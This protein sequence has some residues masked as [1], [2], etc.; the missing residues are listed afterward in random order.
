MSNQNKLTIHKSISTASNKDKA[1]SSLRSP[2]DQ[3]A[4]GTMSQESTARGKVSKNTVSN[5]DL[6]AVESKQFFY[7]P[8]ELKDRE[9][10]IQYSDDEEISNS[11][12]RPRKNEN[13]EEFIEY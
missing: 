6:E 4:P 5:I 12:R 3:L 2:N 8:V 1:R 11:E 13:L 7:Q 9:G 10:M